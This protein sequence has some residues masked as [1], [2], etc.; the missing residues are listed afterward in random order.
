MKIPRFQVVPAPGTDTDA[1]AWRS[2][3]LTVADQAVGPTD[4]PPITVAVFLLPALLAEEFQ[5]QMALL[6]DVMDV[7]ESRT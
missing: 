3:A 7:E 5:R 6:N 1:G 2:L 4:R